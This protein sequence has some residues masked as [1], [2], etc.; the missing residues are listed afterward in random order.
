M[1]V[2]SVLTMRYTQTTFAEAL[3]KTYPKLAIG[4]VGLVTSPTQAEGYLQDGKADVVFLARE[5]IRNPN[6]ALT[7]AAE[8][9][10]A[11]KPA[12]QYE[13][14]WMHMLSPKPAN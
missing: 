10:A 2:T 3:K 6:F 12:N 1:R 7:A 5:L 14:G 8:L 9:G 13:R 11:I 4:T